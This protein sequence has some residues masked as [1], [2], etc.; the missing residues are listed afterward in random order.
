MASELTQEPGYQNIKFVP[1]DDLVFQWNIPFDIT[2]FTF[3]MTAHKENG[4]DYII[5]TTKGSITSTLSVLQARFY[6][7]VTSAFQ[8]LTTDLD[9]EVGRYVLKYVDGSNLTRSFISGLIKIKQV[10]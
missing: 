5:P 10:I 3:T 1:G 4:K 8:Q 6:A 2:S 7:S 9:E